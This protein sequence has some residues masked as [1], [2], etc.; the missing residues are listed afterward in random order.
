MLLK[1]G[2]LARR[3]GL[4]VRTLHH[5][6]E[7]GLLRPSGRSDGGYRLYGAADVARLH[8]IQALR[9][10]N[11]PLEDIAHAL[12]A[13]GGNLQGIV[14]R[15]LGV[16][17]AQIRQAGELR[18]RLRLVQGKFAAGGEPELEDWLATLQMMNTTARYFSGEELQQIFG[19]WAEVDEQWQQLVDEIRVAMAAG[20]AAE[21]GTV[22]RLAQ[23]WMNLMHDWMG[24]DFD[25]MLRWGQMY[26]AE[27]SMHGRGGMDL[28]VVR[29]IEQAVS[30]RL[31]LL[32]RY[33]SDDDL[34]Q[35][36]CVSE[37]EWRALAEPAQALID[38]GTPPDDPAVLP[39]LAQWHGLAQRLSGGDAGL[40]ARLLQA[41][42]AE[43]LLREGAVLP[44]PVREFLHRAADL[45][46]R[47]AAGA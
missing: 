20:L 45:V 30:L 17:E 26:E 7:I 37:R 39:L 12:Q 21:D 40:R 9:A 33:L 16:L 36:G 15:Q 5:Y 34:R 41:H 42:A 32:R 14:E 28:A 46:A 1:V 23:R 38:A 29:Y 43:P 22:Q 11:L 13:G 44:P 2:E 6:D 8:A 47:R 31:A 4:T 35:L 25:R 18:D 19:N 10:L 3:S 24:G 27:P